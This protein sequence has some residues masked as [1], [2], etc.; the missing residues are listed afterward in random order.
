M[1]VIQAPSGMGLTQRQTETLKAITE[2]VACHGVMP[3]RRALAAHIQRAPNSA[4]QQMQALVERGELNT[5]TPGGA[6]S[7]FGREGV[8]VFI[9]SH[10][11]AILA[12]FCLEH[13]EKVTAVVADAI[14]LH[15]DQARGVEE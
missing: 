1:T 5:I 10:I 6:L 15:L 12:A 9:P 4:N 3:S 11:A 13:S 14:V 8:A 2:Y 7:G